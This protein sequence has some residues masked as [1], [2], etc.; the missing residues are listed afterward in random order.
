MTPLI[1]WLPLD[2]TLTD[3]GNGKHDELIRNYLTEINQT[4]GD[5]TVLI[6]LAHEME[7]ND[8]GNW[9]PWQYKGGEKDYIHM[10]RHVVSIGREVAPHVRWIWSPNRMTPQSIRWYPGDEYVDYISITLNHKANRVP[11]YPIFEDYFRQEGVEKHFNRINKKIILSEVGYANQDETRRHPSLYII[12][13]II[14]RGSA[15][16]DCVQVPIRAESMQEKVLEI[17]PR[18]ELGDVFIYGKNRS[19]VYVSALHNDI[20]NREPQK[21]FQEIPL[22]LGNVHQVTRDQKEARHVETIHHL[23]DVG[24]QLLEPHQVESD[25]EQYEHA[26]Q[27]VEFRDA[28]HVVLHLSRHPVDGLPQRRDDGR[29]AV[30]GG[31]FL[32]PVEREW[33]LVLLLQFVLLRLELLLIHVATFRRISLDDEFV[34]SL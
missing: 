27:I 25:D 22:W 1:S 21:G 28:P 8:T 18:R 30:G 12:I 19:H 13:Y 20:R 9:Y 11:S 17:D 32:Q 26:L 10:W 4:Y 16:D 29:N 5:S 31:I 3:I 7:N 34:P 24:V 15:K 23:L 33:R 2:Y 14:V 6:R